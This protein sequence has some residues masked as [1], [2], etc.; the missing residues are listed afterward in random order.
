MRPGQLLEGIALAA[1]FHVL[2]N[3]QSGYL[4]DSGRIGLTSVVILFVAF[5][6]T[7]VA[8]WWWFEG[9]HRRNAPRQPDPAVTLPKVG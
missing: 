6:I 4:A 2:V 5:G 1:F 7:S 9:R 3:P 8:F